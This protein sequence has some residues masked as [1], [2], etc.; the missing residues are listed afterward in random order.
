[1]V[2]TSGL[3][4]RHLKDYAQ[5]ECQFEAVH[6]ESPEDFQ[7]G[8]QLA[9]ALVEQAD[10]AKQQRSLQLA[11]ANVRVYPRSPEALATL[12]RVYH[13]LGRRDEA[14]RALQAA[15]SLGKLGSWFLLLLISYALVAMVNR[16][17]PI[18]SRRTRPQARQAPTT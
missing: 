9:L 1:M 6:Q 12:G 14:E 13:R 3:I 17:Q 7:A 2:V 18:M 4:A 11:E 10:P 16:P 5:A 15:V 8:N